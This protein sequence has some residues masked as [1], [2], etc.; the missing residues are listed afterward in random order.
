MWLRQHFRV[1]SEQFGA[2][3]KHRFG[4]HLRLAIAGG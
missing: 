3:R 4:E 1:I 2:V